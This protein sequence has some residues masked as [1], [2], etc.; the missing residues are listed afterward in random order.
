VGLIDAENALYVRTAL[1]S[2]LPAGVAVPA[3]RRTTHLAFGISPICPDQANPYMSSER[4]SKAPSLTFSKR[5]G[6]GQMPKKGANKV[7]SVLPAASA[8]VLGSSAPVR[9]ACLFWRLTR[10]LARQEARNAERGPSSSS[11]ARLWMP[12]SG[13][14]DR[15][16]PGLT[17]L[18]DGTIE[19]GDISIV[20]CVGCGA[21]SCRCRSMLLS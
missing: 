11:A 9:V 2:S 13:K 16:R 21:R 4:R 15:A 12:D 18:Q 1:Y 19:I 14:L 7:R 5:G 8:A 6:G 3:G 17:L 20:G 10:R